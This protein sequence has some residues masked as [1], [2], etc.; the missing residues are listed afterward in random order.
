MNFGLIE[1]SYGSD[2]SIPEHHELTQ[3]QRF[4]QE[5]GSLNAQARVGTSYRLLFLGRHGEGDHNVAEAFYGSKAWDVRKLS[6]PP[7]PPPFW[8]QPHTPQQEAAHTI[9]IVPLGRP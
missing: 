2:A 3:W 6:P 8:N 9:G 1:R 4:E 5:L 7:S